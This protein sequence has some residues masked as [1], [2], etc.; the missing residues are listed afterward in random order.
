M[1]PLQVA[2]WTRQYRASATEEVPAIES[3]IT[4]LSRNVPEELPGDC[5]IVHGDM[6]FDNGTHSHRSLLFVCE[7]WPRIVDQSVPCGPCAQ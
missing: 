7:A 5:T 1:S 6:K 2:T 4:W 3:L